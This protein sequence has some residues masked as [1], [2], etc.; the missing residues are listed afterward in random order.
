M[1]KHKY[2]HSSLILYFFYLLHEENKEIKIKELT[3]QL[4]ISKATAYNLL[5][6]IDLFI[7]E[8]ELYNL[9]I[10]KS[11]GIITIKKIGGILNYLK[12]FLFIFLFSNSIRHSYYIMY[13]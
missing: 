3:E 2:K 9:E 10:I 6:D 4:E 7:S 5:N 11:N 13:L 8:F 12:H 1:K